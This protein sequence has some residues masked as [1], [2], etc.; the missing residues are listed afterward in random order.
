MTMT[1]KALRAGADV[2]EPASL[3]AVGNGEAVVMV[4]MEVGDHGL[5]KMAVIVGEAEMQLEYPFVL[6]GLVDS[7]QVLGL[8]GIL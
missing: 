8:S 6:E 7:S 5:E 1:L 3:R 4:F 2:P